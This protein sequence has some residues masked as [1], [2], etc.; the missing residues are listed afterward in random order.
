MPTYHTEFSRQH[1]VS[2]LMDVNAL[3][4]L[5]MKNVDHRMDHGMGIK[6]MDHPYLL[7]PPSVPLAGAIRTRG[8]TV[9]AWHSMGS[10]ILIKG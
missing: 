5:D 1:G 2:A 3:T 9:K 7:S 10:C 4:S 8:D 6:A